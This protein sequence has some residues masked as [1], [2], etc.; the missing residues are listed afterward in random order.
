MQNPQLQFPAPSL[1][2]KYLFL[3]LPSSLF[4]MIA[5][6]CTSLFNWQVSVTLAQSTHFVA[7]LVEK[8]EESHCLCE[9]GRKTVA[10][11]VIPKSLGKGLKVS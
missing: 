2:Q 10:W 3:W 4:L 6:N 1:L 5:L 7:T 11:L 9:N 8:E